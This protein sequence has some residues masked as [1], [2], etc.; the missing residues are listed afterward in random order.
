MKPCL[1]PLRPATSMTGCCRRFGAWCSKAVF[2]L[3]GRRS[4]ASPPALRR[5]RPADN[6]RCS[7]WACAGRPTPARRT[8]AHCFWVSHR[9]LSFTTDWRLQETPT[10]FWLVLAFAL[11]VQR[12]PAARFA[13]GAALGLAVVVKGLALLALAVIG[14]GVP[15]AP[16]NGGVIRKPSGLFLNLVLNLTPPLL[17]RGGLC[18]STSRSGTDRTMPSWRGWRRFTASIRCSRIRH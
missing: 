16:N 15:P 13:A 2:G 10:V 3:F 17:G 6:R 9:R 4:P 14:V 8:S 5:L 18:S 11:W 7:G 12:G 1:E